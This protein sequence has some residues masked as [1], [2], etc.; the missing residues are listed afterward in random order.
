MRSA[1]A[2]HHLI[3]NIPAE[4][5]IAV[6]RDVLDTGGGRSIGIYSL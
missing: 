6:P 4:L 1:L 3:D 5:D 2:R